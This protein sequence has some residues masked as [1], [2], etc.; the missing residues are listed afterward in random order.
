MNGQALPPQEVGRLVGQNTE[1]FHPLPL[2]ARE[3]SKLFTARA[4][5]SGDAEGRHVDP[6]EFQ[7]YFVAQG[8][9][10]AGVA[11]TYAPSMIT[12]EATSQQLAGGL[13]HGT[14]R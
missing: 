8:R 2:H 6:E 4:T 11:T 13:N 12:A 14:H 5:E 9:F 1:L 10:T 3:F 7:R